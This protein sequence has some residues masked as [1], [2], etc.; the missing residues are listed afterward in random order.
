ARVVLQTTVLT[1]G[2]FDGDDEE[3]ERQA[4]G[5][6]SE[7]RRPRAVSHQRGSREYRRGGRVLRQAVRHR[8]TETGWLALLLH[9]RRGDAAGGR[10]VV[11]RKT[12]SG[13]ES[14]LLP[15][16]R[17]RRGPRARESARLS[18]AR[19]SPRRLGGRDQR[20]PVGGTL[21]LCGGQVGKSALLRGSGDRVR[22]VTRT[23]RGFR[24]KTQVISIR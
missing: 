13:G 23:K 1:D 19:K 3:D 5:R 4:G 16:R 9:L 20:A 7:C 8:R 6:E 14:A 2:G 24:L 11:S 10:R 18:V 15:R 12:A 22:R 17:P 21:V